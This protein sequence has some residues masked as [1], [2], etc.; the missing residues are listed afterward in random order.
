MITVKGS[1]LNK[2][3]ITKTIVLTAESSSN[4]FA[5]HRYDQDWN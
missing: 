5:L 4:C 3:Y 1:F 2:P